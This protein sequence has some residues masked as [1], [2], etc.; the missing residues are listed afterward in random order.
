MT[1][2]YSQYKLLHISNRGQLDIDF[3]L[4]VTLVVA[5]E[6]SELMSQVLDGVYL[7]FS[8]DR[9]LIYLSHCLASR[10]IL[11]T[12]AVVDNVRDLNTRSATYLTKDCVQERDMFDNQ[13]DVVD[14]NLIANIVWMFDE[15]EDTRTE[16]FLDGSC[17]GKR[18][19][20]NAAPQ[21]RCTRGEGCIKKCGYKWLV[22]VGSRNSTYHKQV[23]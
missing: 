21:G 11:D 15:D 9:K 3:R 22:R 10:G 17:D 13:R 19:R 5:S 14:V 1:D 7:S 12:L 4:E 20:G 2:S 23:P 16:E 6:I 18:E 8:V